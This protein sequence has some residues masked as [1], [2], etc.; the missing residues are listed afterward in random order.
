MTVKYTSSHRYGIWILAAGL[1]TTIF[2]ISL[3]SSSMPSTVLVVN[4]YAQENEKIQNLTE[5]NIPKILP[6]VRGFADG[7]EVFYITTE[8]SDE[9]LANYL[10][11][12]TNS[13]VVYTPALKYAPPQSLANIYEFT[14]GI[15][16]SGPE[17]FQ[18]NIADSQPGD[19][20]YSP[21]WKVNFVTWNNSTTQEN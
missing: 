3:F 17:G 16:G 8:V 19:N 7:N 15:K 12:L 20:N 2:S 6:L 4:S 21:L 11:N 1:L 9:K 18:P 13:R 14:N 10:T 5:T